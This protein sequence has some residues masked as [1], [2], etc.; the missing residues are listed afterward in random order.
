MTYSVL[1]LNAAATTE[2]YTLSLHDALP[3]SWS[4]FRRSAH[5][6]RKWS[7]G[8]REW[9]CRFRGR[10]RLDR[11][12]GRRR[13]V[14]RRSRLRLCRRWEL[15]RRRVEHDRQID[16]ATR[17]ARSRAAH[18]KWPEILFSQSQRADNPWRQ[19][20]DD[21]GFLSLAAVVREQP[22]HERK[23]DQARH[24]LDHPALVVADQTRQQVRL[25]V[26]QADHGAD[27]AVAECRQ[28]AE[29]GA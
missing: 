29:P 20:Q 26:L 17:A 28:I 5:A 21:V 16:Y 23:I 3:I 19:R 11:R 12:R 10:R 22:A 7:R 4:A 13:S 25:A 6:S 8:L 15:W 1:L 27:L 14:G 2:I 24:P 9:R 18:A